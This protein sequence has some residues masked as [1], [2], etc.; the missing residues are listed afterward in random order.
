MNEHLGE[1]SDHRS[2]KEYCEQVGG[3]NAGTE[4]RP[5]AVGIRN[6]WIVSVLSSSVSVVAAIPLHCAIL[7]WFSR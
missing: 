2:R 6:D 1:V 5:Y 4:W 7:A 3:W